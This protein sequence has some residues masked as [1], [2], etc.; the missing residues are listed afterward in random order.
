M[1]IHY[2]RYPVETYFTTCGRWDRDKVTRI[3]SKV[4]CKR[5]RRTKNFRGIK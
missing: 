2:A 3:K 1:K 5:C 4:T